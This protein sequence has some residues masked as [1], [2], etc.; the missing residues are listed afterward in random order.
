MI[1]NL[2]K[3]SRKNNNLKKNSRKKNLEENNMR[4]SL[5]KRK[6]DISVLLRKRV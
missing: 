6:D 5:K 2:K 4:F 1:F 3:N